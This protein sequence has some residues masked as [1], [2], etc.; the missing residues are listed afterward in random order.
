MKHNFKIT[1]IWTFACLIVFVLQL[2]GV[3]DISNYAILPSAVKAG[4]YYR[5]LTGALMHAG[6]QHLFAN[7]VSFLNVG[8]Y[9]EDRTSVKSYSAAVLMSLIMSGISVTLFSEGYTV[10][11]SGVVFGILGYFA[12]LLYKD[13][14][15]WN[16]RDRYLIGRMIVPNIIISFMPGVSLAGHAGG[17]LGG[18]I[19]GLLFIKQRR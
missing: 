8:L 12:I 10:G 9:C 17:F 2:I 5:L 13:D 1:Y 11:F 19:A 6:I 14:G 18:I 3:L 7:M 16:E 4:Q 15:T